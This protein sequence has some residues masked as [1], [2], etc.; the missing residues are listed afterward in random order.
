MIHVIDLHFQTAQ[1][2]AAFVVE[3]SAGPVLVETGPHSV[4][5]S[6]RAGLA[7]IGYQ[8]SDIQHVLLSH[9]HF[10]HAGAAWALAELGATIYVHPAGY[11]HLQ[12]PTKLYQSAKRIYGDAMESLWGDMRV[13][14]AEHLVAVDHRQVITVGDH[15]FQAW[16]TPGHASHH[17]AWQ[18]SEAIFTGDVAGVRIG[19]GPAMPPCPPPDIFLEAWFDS[20]DTLRQ[21]APARLYL[22]HFGPVEEVSAHLDQLQHGL[23]TWADWMKPAFEAGRSPEEVT[24]EFQAYVAEELRL[25]GLDAAGVAQYEAANPAWMSVAGLLRYWKKR[26][27]LLAT[28]QRPPMA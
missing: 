27:D 2:I 20:I 24:P 4:F 28:Y 11:Q 21:L 13:I 8:P 10:D 5:E 23:R 1:T 19:N 12:D 22:T 14:E 6:L 16:H 9:I 15:R 17:I 26:T 3:T 18:T 7:T 25:A